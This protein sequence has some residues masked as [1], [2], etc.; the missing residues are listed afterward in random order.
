MNPPSK[1]NIL[2]YGYRL[3]KYGGKKKKSTETE[4]PLKQKE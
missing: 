2:N 1:I 3:K 4:H